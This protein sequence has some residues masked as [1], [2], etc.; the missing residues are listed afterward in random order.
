MTI[1]IAIK[2]EQRLSTLQDELGGIHMLAPIERFQLE[3]ATSVI[4]H[5]K[6]VLLDWVSKYMDIYGVFVFP[7][8][9]PVSA[10]PDCR[11]AWFSYDYKSGPFDTAF[12]ALLDTKKRI[13]DN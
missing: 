9:E 10:D 6:A 3:T 7:R 4:I 5:T 8:F 1:E 11:F 13:E 2:E 12:E